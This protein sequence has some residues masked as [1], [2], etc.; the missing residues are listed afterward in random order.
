[1]AS[2]SR[3]F[4][5]FKMNNKEVWRQYMSGVPSQRLS[6]ILLCLII[7]GSFPPKFST[8]HHKNNKKN[9]NN[10]INLVIGQ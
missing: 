2:N 6:D 7:I 10:F 9:K 5:L 8:H 1:M 3:L 4:N